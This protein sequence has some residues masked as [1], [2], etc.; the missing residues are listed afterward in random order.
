M[1]APDQNVAS[2]LG[3]QCFSY[4]PFTDFQVQE[5]VN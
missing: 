4:D 1:G 2:D 5:Q 3:L